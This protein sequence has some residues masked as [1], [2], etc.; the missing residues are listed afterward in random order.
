M[1]KIFT[2]FAAM[3][4]V[5][6][7][8]ATTIYC[9]MTQG[10]WTAD[11]AAVGAYAWSGDG[12][13]AQKNADWPGVRMSALSSAAGIWSIDIPAQYEKIIFTRVNADGNIADWGA[14]TE[15]LVIPIDGNNMFTITTE[16]ACWNSQGCACS[17]SWSVYD[18]TVTPPGP[19]PQPGAAKDYLLKGWCNEKDIET[20]T[21][22]ELFEGGMLTYTFTGD[23]NFHKGWFFILV[24]EPG[25]VI[26]EQYMTKGV[27][28]PSGTHTTLYKDGFEK[29]GVPEGTVTF[30]LYDNGDGTFEFSTEPLPGKTLVGGGSQGITNTTVR[31]KAYKTIIDGQLR[32]IRG[33]KM[34]D[35]T[36]RQL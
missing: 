27:D 28:D 16:D 18:G 15:D 9:Q 5:G 10:W 35:A 3:L 6:S 13:N 34:F 36:G 4:M 29:F 20:P 33:D 14:K 19:G 21:A 12:D 32:I 11:G 7:A 30:Y 2:L 22:E 8:F 24:C 17:G 23:A 31:E 25:Q 26:G 1:K